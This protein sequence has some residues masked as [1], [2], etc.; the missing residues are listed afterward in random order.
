MY[1]PS[2][3]RSATLCHPVYQLLDQ[4]RFHINHCRQVYPIHYCT[5]AWQGIVG[6]TRILLSCGRTQLVWWVGGGQVALV[7]TI[8]N[9][10]QDVGSYNSMHS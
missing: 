9:T 5:R 1:V 6:E 4:L 7:A 3:G 10:W 8:E 2:T